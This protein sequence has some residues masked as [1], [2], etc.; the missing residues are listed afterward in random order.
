MPP[1]PPIGADYTYSPNHGNSFGKQHKGSELTA[2][3]TELDL[4]PGTAT[5]VL[6]IEADTGRILVEWIDDKEIG[7]ITSIDQQEFNTDFKKA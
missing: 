2:E 4:K 6:D 3:M 1:A 7:R 5:T